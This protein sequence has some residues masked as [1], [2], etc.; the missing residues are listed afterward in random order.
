MF[1]PKLAKNIF[2]SLNQL[3]YVRDL[4]KNI[5]FMNNKAE[6]YT[7]ITSEEAANVKKCYEIFSNTGLCK[8][9]CPV[10]LFMKGTGRTNSFEKVLKNRDSINRYFEASVSPFF[11]DGHLQ[12]CIIFF[13][14]IAE[15]K[16]YESIYEETIKQLKEEIAK[17]EL[18]EK[19]LLESEKKYRTTFEYT[20][21]AMIVIDEDR[22]ISMA[23]KEVERLT[24]YL[25][26]EFVGISKWDQFVHPGERKWLGSYHK[27]RRMPDGKVPNQYEFRLIDKSGNIKE[28]FYTINLIPGSKQ[29]IGSLIDITDRKKMEKNL[30]QSEEK[31]RT[32][33]ENIEDGYYEVNLEGSLLY[34]NEALI[35][36]YGVPAKKPFM[37]INY[38]NYT[39]A[40]NAEIIYKAYN[41]VFS[42]GKPEKGFSLEITRKDG[43]KRI[44]EVSISL[45]RD[46]DGQPTG[47]RGIVRDVTERRQAEERLKYLSMHDVM[48][49]L[50]NRTYFEEEM[51]R[52]NKGRFSPVTII[53]CDVD[54]LKLINDTFGHKKGD[55]LLKGVADILKE[56]FRASDLV[57]RT[58]GDEFSI[59]LPYTNEDAAQKICDR[60]KNAIVH[61]N[62]EAERL[63]I[64][65]SIGMATG[66]I[67]KRINCDHL[68]KQA[69]NNMYRHKL[70]SKVSSK[71][72]LLKSII[73][74]LDERDFLAEGHADRLYRLA[75][76]LVEAANLSD[77]EMDDIK[78]LSKYHDIGKAGIPDSILFKPGPLNKKEWEEMKEHSEIG[79]RIAKST[80]ELSYIANWILSHHEW[81]NGKGYPQGLKGNQIPILSRIIFIADA[82]DAMT[83]DRP[84]RKALSH[85][86]AVSEIERCAGSQF[87]P[88]LTELFIKTLS[89][90]E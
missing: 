54:D 62:N 82:Y 87:D 15:L 11:S 10:D 45:V 17:R 26:E 73:K 12:G 27:K 56:P 6:D 1:D 20:G 88:E 52:I 18:L 29:S 5:I 34:C 3:V 68:Y 84:Y 21:T 32:L 80:P 35:R 38:R 60:I 9:K 25:Q 30:R 2:S 33:L 61:H 65:L 57:A 22:T 16:N 89:Q 46:V 83:N 64:S 76:R 51:T 14:D 67:S 23:N 69:D 78:M 77:R 40:K 72:L 66:N 48:T 59:I 31:Y 43:E 19:S 71:N 7:G 44:V 24:G 4:K 28:I 70:K 81:W 75:G 42:T 37:G 36:I 85:K 63:P 13:K 55:E 41:K 58:G 49:G 86:E 74:T 50:Y 47:F 53:C 8:D 39:D 90:P 79:F